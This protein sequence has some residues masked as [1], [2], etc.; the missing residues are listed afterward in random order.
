MA[1][2]SCNYHLNAAN[3]KRVRLFSRPNLYRVCILVVWRTDA[4]LLRSSQ[5]AQAEKFGASVGT[6]NNDFLHLANFV[7]L[8]IDTRVST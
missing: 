2:L 3:K 7:L 4:R 8:K 1:R 6:E 5:A